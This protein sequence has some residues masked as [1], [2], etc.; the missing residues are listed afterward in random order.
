MFFNP[1]HASCRHLT[2]HATVG[3]W[4]EASG[5]GSLCCCARAETGNG[6]SRGWRMMSSYLRAAGGMGDK[7]MRTRAR[8]RARNKGEGWGEGGRG[9]V[10]SR[11]P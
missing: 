10:A 3:P 1:C 4:A 7:V 11:V 8:A 2:W 6:S 5:C 9:Q